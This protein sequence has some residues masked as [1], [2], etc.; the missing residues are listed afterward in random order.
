MFIVTPPPPPEVRCVLNV[1]P[2]FHD[3]CTS[4][5]HGSGCE[6]FFVFFDGNVQV[7]LI[8]QCHGEL[9]VSFCLGVFKYTIGTVIFSTHCT[10]P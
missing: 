3:T 6:L 9:A 10:V 8:V 7:F 5:K 4:F 2:T 1:V